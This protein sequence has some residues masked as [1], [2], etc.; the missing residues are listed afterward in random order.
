M[1]LEFLKFM[2]GI[3]RKWKRKG[4]VLVATVLAKAAAMQQLAAGR[5]PC[6][7]LRMRVT[8]SCFALTFLKQLLDA[9]KPLHRP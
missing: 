7:P 3:K 5:R 9:P 1:F 8:R 6:S 2:F 4:A